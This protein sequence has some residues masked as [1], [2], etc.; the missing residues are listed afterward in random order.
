MDS[1]VELRKSSRQTVSGHPRWHLLTG[2]SWNDRLEEVQTV[3]DSSHFLS[4]DWGTTHFRLRLVEREGLRVVDEVREDS[5]AKTIHMNLGDHASTAARAQAFARFLRDRME[6]LCRRNAPIASKLPVMISGM[7]SSSVGWRELAYASVPFPLDGS[8]MVLERIP[9]S[10]VGPHHGPVWLLSGISSGR[11]MM[12]GEESEILG[13]MACGAVNSD[14][15]QAGILLLPG[16]HSKH[17]WLKGSAIVEF[18][19]HMTGEL[20][21]ILARHSLLKSSVQWP[22]SSA[23]PDY[24][25]REAFEAGVLEAK[26]WGLGTSLFQVRVRHV[27]GKSDPENNGW[28]LSGL[29]IGDEVLRLL[30]VASSLQIVLAG[31]A[32]LQVAYELAFR[33]LGVGDQLQVIPGMLS[34][35]A[36]VHAQAY[37]LSTRRLSSD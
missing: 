8:G 7:A 35:L 28:F 6:L 31:S 12:R 1:R 32:R 21:D 25:Q 5:G 3:N 16:T 26:E 30:G 18:R 2:Q 20:C 19:T 13:L 9:S 17:V 22:L 11:D 37:L 15:L 14:V 34:E 10:E 33:A 23:I 29:I 4:C 24:K 36:S 27:L